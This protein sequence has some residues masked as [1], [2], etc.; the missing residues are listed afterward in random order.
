MN[1]TELFL[2]TLFCCS[3]C[4]G[5]IA[6]EEITLVKDFTSSSDMFQDINVEELLNGYVE[7]INS[8][9][10][11]FLKEFLNELNDTDISEEDQLT[12]LDLAIRMI[13]ADNQ[14]LYPEVKFF[15]KLRQQLDIKDE[16]IFEI[17][18]Q[19]ED[20]LL[21]DIRNDHKEDDWTN[22][23]FMPISLSLH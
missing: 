5:D 1:I 20:Y 21:P 16:K 23:S 10:K 2:K 4:D 15:K 12:L 8:I 22:I 6:H 3:A 13:E 17:L 14:I 18:P 11:N 19:A 9:G 7:R